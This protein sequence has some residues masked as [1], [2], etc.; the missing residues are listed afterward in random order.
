MPSYIIAYH[1]E[2]KTPETPDEGAAH[3]Q[4]WKDWVTNL[5]DAVV[6]PGSPIGPSKLVSPTG[7]AEDNLPDAMSGFS[8]VKA[9]TL[10]AALEMAKS[11]PYVE[12]GGTLRVAQLIEMGG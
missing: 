3:M 1:G 4:Q 8:V 5:G 11:C 6:N 12:V 10:D 9:D 7:I 2:I